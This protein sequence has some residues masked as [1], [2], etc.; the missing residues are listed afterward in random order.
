MDRFEALKTFVAV[1]EENGFSRAATELGVSKSVASRQISAL[2]QA[3]GGR[4]LERTTRRVALTDQGRVYLARAKAILAELDAADR[5]VAAPQKDLSGHIRMASPEAFGASRLA[6]VAA[7]FMAANPKITAEIVLTEREVDPGTEGFDLAVRIVAAGLDPS[8]A[9]LLAP[10][11]TGLFATPGY[12]SKHGRPQA[13]GD[14]T[15][16]AVVVLGAQSRQFFWHL[17]G[18]PEPVPVTPRLASNNAHM[19]RE[20]ALAGLGIALLPLFTVAEDVKAGRL[21]RVLDGFEPKPAWLCAEYP[22]G[23]A[24]SLTARRFV[25]FLIERLRSDG[26]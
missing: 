16:H 20:A 3:L 7:R 24:P 25:E 9:A 13:P 18:Q 15:Q 26:A 10:V 6:P 14:L 23:R 17:R 2:E 5:D 8:P 4:L 21:M 1:A 11:E 19:V 12:L 22:A